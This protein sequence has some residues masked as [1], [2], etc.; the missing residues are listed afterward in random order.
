MISLNEVKTDIIIKID[1]K[2]FKIQ[3]VEHT[4]LGRGGAILRTKIK[5]LINGTTI[6]KTFRGNDKIE[7]VYL[8][9]KKYQYLYSEEN[10]YYF[11]DPES[12]EQITIEKEHIEDNCR[13]LR[14]GTKTEILF[15]E[16]NPIAINIP[17]KMTF[18]ITYTEPG[19][20]GDTKSSTALKPATLDTGA[21]IKV[22]LFIKTG[23]EII[24]D[25]RSGKYVERA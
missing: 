4:K 18:K 16:N 13:Y 2:P 10:H 9:R 21:E 23:D 14:E 12:F 3:W 1:N 6:E 17:I 8:E 15:Y 19:L 11:M 20:R 25:T 5:N 7:K 24:I 22:P